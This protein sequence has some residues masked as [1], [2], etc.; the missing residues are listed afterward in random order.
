M[1]FQ[2]EKIPQFHNRLKHLCV[3]AVLESRFLCLVIHTR[4]VRQPPPVKFKEIPVWC[5]S[6]SPHQH[7]LPTRPY[8]PVYLIGIPSILSTNMMLLKR[9]FSSILL[10]GVPVTGFVRP[11]S[12]PMTHRP[13]MQSGSSAMKMLDGSSSM[14]AELATT[15]ATTIGSMELFQSNTGLLLA[16]TEG[17]VQPT[18]LILGPFLNFLSFAMVRPVGGSSFS[19]SMLL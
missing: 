9:L 19:M 18:A 8:I 14:I 17:W 1:L 10:L 13:L 5:T 6:S 3:V 15:T 4:H 2:N 7:Q 12:L 16:E 11:L